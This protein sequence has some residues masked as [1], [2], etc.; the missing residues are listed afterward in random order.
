MPEMKYFCYVTL[1]LLAAFTIVFAI[2]QIRYVNKR[3]KYPD[4]MDES[5]MASQYF[6]YWKINISM[7]IS[8]VLAFVWTFLVTGKELGILV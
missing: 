5:R 6:H 2:E 4:S 1:M 8:W 7:L 3:R